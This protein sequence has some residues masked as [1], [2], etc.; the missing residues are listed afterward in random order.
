MLNK[1]EVFHSAIK[2]KN[3][4][5][6]ATKVQVKNQRKKKPGLLVCLILALCLFSPA[7]HA[8]TLWSAA[9]GR[10]AGGGTLIAKNR[11]WRP[12]H[13][14]KLVLVKGAGFRYLALVAVG[15]DAPGAKGGVNEH[16]L[17]VVSASP[18][19]YLRNDR[20]IERSYG[21]MRK[22]L[23][24]CRT[25]EDALALGSLFRGPQFLLLADRQEIASIEI[26]LA[27]EFRIARSSDGT[28][29]HTNHY[30]EDEFVSLNRGKPSATSLSRHQTIES[31]LRAFEELELEHFISFSFLQ[32]KG[33]NQSIWRTG[34]RPDSART[35]SSLIV[36]QPA[37]GEPLLFIRMNN[38]G[39]PL[40]E[41]QF[42]LR[43]IFAGEVDLDAVK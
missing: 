5:A 38:P 10:V 7:V 24:Q 9:G 18:P 43:E 11:D 22:I 1:P 40:R 15:N 33:P 6:E 20:S 19:A 31:L 17:T 42:R 14:Q 39:N 34:S 29:T 41:Y 21:L 2:L 32:D 8:C 28:L 12:D 3:K 23:S 27:G 37:D 16:G 4:T 26:G 36:S 25:V 30:L 35:L 13:W